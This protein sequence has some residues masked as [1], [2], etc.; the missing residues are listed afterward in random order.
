MVMYRAPH[1]GCYRARTSCAAA[2]HAASARFTN[3]GPY[4]HSLTIEVSLFLVSQVTR[5]SV[6]AAVLSP[7]VFFAAPGLGI[8]RCGPAPVAVL[9]PP[10]QAKT[11]N[12]GRGLHITAAISGTIA[13]GTEIVFD[14]G[15]D[16]LRRGR[17][18]EVFKA[19]AAF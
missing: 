14:A 1:D 17:S 16:P 19:T 8:F 3:R 12:H 11:V 10:R 18:Q 6:F 13:I 7:A 4:T 5:L 2:R 9:A 15:R